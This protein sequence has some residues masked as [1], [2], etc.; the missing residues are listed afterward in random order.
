[1]QFSSLSLG[2]LASVCIELEQFDVQSRWLSRV[3]TANLAA[4]WHFISEF[5]FPHVTRSECYGP[6]N[7]FGQREHDEFLLKGVSLLSSRTPKEC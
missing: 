2:F 6:Q 1:M 7:V 5:V 3:Y 4:K